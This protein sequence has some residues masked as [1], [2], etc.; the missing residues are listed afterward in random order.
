MAESGW[1]GSVDIWWSVM[2]GLLTC[3]GDLQVYKYLGT[4]VLTVIGPSDNCLLLSFTSGYEMKWNGYNV[5][6]TY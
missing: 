2:T 5:I 4:D 1:T 6:P 3:L